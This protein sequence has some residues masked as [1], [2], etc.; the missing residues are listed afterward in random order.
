MNRIPFALQIPDTAAFARALAQ[1]LREREQAGKP[2]PG[3][4][5]LLNLLARAVG[6]RNVQ[7]LKQ[8]RAA[9]PQAPVALE[10]RAALPLSDHARRAL[11][12]FDS[13]GRLV[14]WPAKRA[15]QK[16][17]MWPL[18]MRFDADR[19]YTEAEVNTVLK[20]AN[21]FGDHVT[22]RRELI[23]DRLMARTSDCRQ[24]RKLPARPGDEARAL[25]QAWRARCREEAQVEPAAG[26]PRAPAP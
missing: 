22:L 6:Q 12:L 17:C 14:Q 1:S 15:V 11:A 23:N 2:L 16:L 24:Y 26:Q 13:R 9:V 7:A 19:P 5:E 4:V 8:Q 25:M 21:A 20:T 3:H 18:W 10:D